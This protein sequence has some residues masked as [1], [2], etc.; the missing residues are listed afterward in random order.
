M[1][2]ENNNLGG[3]FISSS[4]AVSTFGMKVS[5]EAFAIMSS[6]IYQFKI[7]A[8]VREYSCNAC[9]GHAAANS[10]E[11]YFIRAPSAIEQYMTITDNGIGL[12]DEGVR[13]IFAV[14]FQSTKKNTNKE[15]GFLGLGAKSGYAYADSFSII[16]R[17]DG[18]KRIYSTYFNAEGIPELNL[19]TE[20]ATEEPNGV[21]IQIPVNMN[22][23]PTFAADIGYIASFTTITPTLEGATLWDSEI[24]GELNNKGWAM[25]SSNYPHRLSS[26]YQIETGGI[27]VVMGG[28]VYPMDASSVRSVLDEMAGDDKIS[29]S[30]YQVLRHL[31]KIVYIDMEM[32]SV[33]FA[34]SRESLSMTEKTK[35]NI[36]SRLR[37]IIDSLLVEARA[38]ADAAPHPVLA[39]RALKSTL[40]FEIDHKWKGVTDLNIISRSVRFIPQTLNAKVLVKYRG[41]SGDFPEYRNMSM[42]RLYGK[43]KLIYRD[44]SRQ[45]IV[46]W[47][48]SYVAND[49]QHNIEAYIVI[50]SPIKESQKKRLMYL[51]GMTEDDFIASSTIVPPKSVRVQESAAGQYRVRCCSVALDPLADYGLLVG[52]EVLDLSEKDKDGN[53]KLK[54]GV[55]F[56][57]RYFNSTTTRIT[58]EFNENR[59]NFDPMYSDTA[60]LLCSMGVERVIFRNT[61][62]ENKIDKLGVPSLAN[63]I[64]EYFVR[65]RDV[66]IA[67]LAQKEINAAA[68]S[69][70][71]QTLRL[72]NEAGSRI[73]ASSM[74]STDIPNGVDAIKTWNSWCDK[75]R[76]IYRDFYGIADEVRAISRPIVTALQK[77]RQEMRDIVL[78]NYP[79][80]SY[81]GIAEEGSPEWG[82]QIEYIRLLDEKWEKD[83]ANDY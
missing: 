12:D 21:S 58:L 83:N 52:Q 46:K 2:Q 65:N 50:G 27:G 78:S 32:G 63:L 37:S 48:R 11:P 18:I 82:H 73:I 4:N 13:H 43:T 29:K 72:L 64:H 68:S 23:I 44:T 77:Y 30:Y 56:I 20:H 16:A 28:V 55:A 8:V 76:E 39:H 49:P 57:T 80:I 10:T 81:N 70:A 3:E 66:A 74:P 60:A 61:S 69:S 40:G 34:A 17:K 19:M 15:T 41:K 9:D 51:L 6:Q 75:T 24:R 7:A 25:R 54:E 35:K 36:D 14:Y 26:L 62:N 67:A 45:G 47:A 71:M 1:I 79:L 33:D 59:I 53:P 38:A 42:E 5:P 31:N 22:D